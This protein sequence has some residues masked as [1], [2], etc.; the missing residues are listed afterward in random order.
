MTTPQK[1]VCLANMYSMY[2]L[3]PASRNPSVPLLCTYIEAEEELPRAR[4]CRLTRADTQPKEG[5]IGPYWPRSGCVI[6]GPSSAGPGYG[7]A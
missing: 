6:C 5:Y 7:P 3:P 2:G 4:P 1:T